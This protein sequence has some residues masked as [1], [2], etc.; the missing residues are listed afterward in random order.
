MF[1]NNVHKGREPGSHIMAIELG[2]PS[3]VTGQPFTSVFASHAGGDD[4]STGWTFLDPHTHVYPPIKPPHGYAGACPTIRYVAADDHYYLL[5]LHAETGG[6]GEFLVRSKDLATWESAA[7]NPILDWKGQV[8]ADKGAPPRSAAWNYY[9]NFTASQEKFIAEA[10]DIN[11]SDIDFVDVNGAPLAS[12]RSARTQTVLLGSHG[13]HADHHSRRQHPGV[14]PRA[15]RGHPGTVY[16]TY[17]WGN[18]VGTEFL[19]AAEVKGTTTDQ[20]LASYF[21]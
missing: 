8:P 21:V 9:A 14:P 11:N 1:N 17:S 10:R 19:G 12:H 3:D 15:T 6:Y 13:G 5:T 16:I 20:W 7:A 4:L 18:Q 2:K